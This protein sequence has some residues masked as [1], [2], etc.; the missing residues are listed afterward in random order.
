MGV[1]DS[2]DSN[3]IKKGGNTTKG[4][5]SATSFKCSGTSVPSIVRMLHYKSTANQ[6]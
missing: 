2:L 3:L 4:Y 5:V 1:E 6:E